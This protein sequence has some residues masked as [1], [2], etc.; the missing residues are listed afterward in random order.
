MT[1]AYLSLGSNI[2]P[3]RHMHGAIA[4]L[5]QRYG[6]L[7]ISPVYQTPAVGFDGD[8]FL[9]LVVGLETTQG[10]EELAAS[11]HEI[12]AELGRRRGDQRYS[13]R[14]MDIDVLTLGDMVR[15][16]APALPRDEILKYAF[17]LKPLADIAPQARHPVVGRCYADIWS[18]FAARSDSADA[19][20][21]VAMDFSA[22]ISG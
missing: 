22:D 10:P 15:D 20:Q 1:Q 13:A 5:Y 9:N 21:P 6:E 2:E 4:A 18:A 8:D 16:S 3:A 11:C 17:V 14:T 19:M 7:V 12:E